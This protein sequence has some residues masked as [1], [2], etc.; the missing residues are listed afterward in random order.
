[1]IKVNKP[2]PEYIIEKIKGT[3]TC[4]VFVHNT[5]EL[6]KGDEYGEAVFHAEVIYPEV[7]NLFTL[8]ISTLNMCT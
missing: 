5:E 1:M 4:D 3:E 8:K 6:I 2:E 7:D